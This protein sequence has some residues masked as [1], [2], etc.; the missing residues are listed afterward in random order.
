MHSSVWTASAAAAAAAAAIALTYAVA[1]SHA[2]NDGVFKKH[3]AAAASSRM[4]ERLCSF[5]SGL[6]VLDDLETSEHNLQGQRR[7]G[8]NQS[9]SNSKGIHA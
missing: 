6:A 1:T 4:P 9:P 8:G 3:N 7:T 2:A 5:L